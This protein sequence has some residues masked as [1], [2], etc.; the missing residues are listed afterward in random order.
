MILKEK[1]H[2]KKEVSHNAIHRWENFITIHGG[3]EGARNVFEKAM[4]ELLSAENQGEGGPYP[5][6]QSGTG[7]GGIDVYVHHEDGID[8]YQCKFFTRI[9]R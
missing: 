1:D 9:D 2:N 8:I 7:D 4:D 5:Y 3:L 6:S